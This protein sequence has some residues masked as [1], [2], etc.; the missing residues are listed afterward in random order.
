ERLQYRIRAFLV[1]VGHMN[2]EGILEGVDAASP[3]ND[4]LSVWDKGEDPLDAVGEHLH[5]GRASN[6][7]LF[8]C[9]EHEEQ[10]RLLYRQSTDQAIERLNKIVQGR[11]LS[12]PQIG[13]HQ[14]ISGGCRFELMEQ[15]RALTARVQEAETTGDQFDQ[16]FRIVWFDFGMI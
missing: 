12:Q 5:D 15:A 6:L 3:R 8:E 10:R 9:V 13:C 7:R 11:S 16:F 14:R 1:E 2:R 4:D